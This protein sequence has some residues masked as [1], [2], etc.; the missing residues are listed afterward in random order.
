MA[1]STFF[2]DE[3]SI[4]IPELN[5]PTISVF[6]VQPLE[7]KHHVGWMDFHEYMETD[8]LDPCFLQKKFILD[9]V[10]V[11]TNVGMRVLLKP[12][13]YDKRVIPSYLSLLQRL[14]NEDR[15]SILDY[16]FHL[17]GWLKRQIVALRFHSLHL[18][19]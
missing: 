8:N 13:R 1:S 2:N 19:I 10:T 5:Q 17:A 6:D 15:L 12:K 7:E 11:A 9:L 4:V 14:A 3:A 18:D 16:R